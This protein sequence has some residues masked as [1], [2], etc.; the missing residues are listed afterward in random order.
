MVSSATNLYL[1]IPEIFKEAYVYVSACPSTYTLAHGQVHLPNTP[2]TYKQTVPITCNTG[3]ELVGVGFITCLASESWSTTSRC[4]LKGK[5]F[6]NR[7]FMC[8]LV[9]IIII[10]FFSIKNHLQAYIQLTDMRALSY[11]KI[12]TYMQKMFHESLPFSSAKTG[13]KINETSPVRVRVDRL[14]ASCPS[15]KNL[16]GTTVELQWLEHLWDHEN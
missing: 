12:S 2:A 15:H 7:A 5:Y 9:F 10:N 11:R 8:V 13:D 14:T 16:K 6:S 3:Y 1:E 4:R